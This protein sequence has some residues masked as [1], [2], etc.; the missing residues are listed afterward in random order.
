MEAILWL[1]R[2]ART[3]THAA[4]PSRG[5]G[6]KWGLNYG[7]RWPGDDPQTEGILFGIRG[8]I[9]IPIPD[10]RLLSKG[11]ADGNTPEI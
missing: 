9:A 7:N 10:V 2:H 6:E 11:K 1:A 5:T 4:P 8:T 3:V